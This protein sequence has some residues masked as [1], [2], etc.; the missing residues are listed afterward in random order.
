[1]GK[2]LSVLD[3]GSWSTVKV[4]HV[5]ADGV[6]EKAFKVHIYNGSAWKESHKTAHTEYS[7]EDVASV[8]DIQADDN[9]TVPTGVRYIRVRIWG[10]SGSGGGGYT[11]EKYY[12]TGQ[13]QYPNAPVFQ[14]YAAGGHGGAGGYV[15]AV[16]ETEPGVTFSWTGFSSSTSYLTGG[17]GTENMISYYGGTDTPATGLHHIA[18]HTYAG[19]AV[20]ETHAGSS[21]N[22]K[23]AWHA[24]HGADAPNIVFTGNSPTSGDPYIL[25]AEGG[26]KGH[27]AVVWITAGNKT[28]GYLVTGLHTYT[29]SMSSGNNFAQGVNYLGHTSNSYDSFTGSGAL[30]FWDLSDRQA[31]GI[32]NGS[33]TATGNGSS[34]ASTTLTS[35][36]GESAVSG[37]GVPLESDGAGSSIFNGKDGS[38]GT[39]GK[40]TIET[41]Q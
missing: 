22:S 3:N 13:T 30:D 17:L 38:A 5:F 29:F 2:S 39:T 14:T 34:F 6:W 20:Y 26:G 19:W 36:G 28:G 4:P 15:E 10:H 8:T 1:M 16:L 23:A 37:G 21:N 32:Y 27:G 12:Q 41:Y 35:G 9:W 11:T 31:N 33:A 7:L 24:G 18:P 25:T 40:I